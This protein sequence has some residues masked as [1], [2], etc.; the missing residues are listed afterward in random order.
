MCWEPHRWDLEITIPKWILLWAFSS[1]QW[2]SLP[3][4]SATRNFWNPGEINVWNFRATLWPLM[5]R[6]WLYPCE[7]E[8]HL[9]LTVGTIWKQ[10]NITILPSLLVP[11]LPLSLLILIPWGYLLF[12]CNSHLKPLFLNHITLSEFQLPVL[13]S[14]QLIIFYHPIHSSTDFYFYPY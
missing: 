1:T 14:L 10:A 4:L 3:I 6:P 12:S 2:V 9:I 13:I 5:S 7:T 8:F 11:Q